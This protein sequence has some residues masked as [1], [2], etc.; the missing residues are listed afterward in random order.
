MEPKTTKA[1][2]GVC[3]R[4]S[5][6]CFL[7]EFEKF[8]KMWFSWFS[9]S[10]FFFFRIYYGFHYAKDIIFGTYDRKWAYMKK[11]AAQGLR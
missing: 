5:P 11:I 9:T 6:T 3:A 4:P 8:T 10:L 1:M 2:N 7:A